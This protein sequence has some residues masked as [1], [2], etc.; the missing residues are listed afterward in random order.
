MKMNVKEEMCEADINAMEMMTVCFKEED[1][2]WKSAHPNQKSLCIKD[3]DY[4]LVT[5]DFKEEN[6]EMPVSDETHKH[7]IMEHV[8]HKVKSELLQSDTKMTEGISSVITPE[9]QL[10]PTNQSEENFPDSHSFHQSASPQIFLQC[11][12]QQAPHEDN[13]KKSTSGS[14]IFTPTSLQYKSS[15]AVQLTSNDT[16]NNL[17]GVHSTNKNLCQDMKTNFKHK[18]RYNNGQWSH[19]GQKLYSCPDCDKQFSKKSS[20]LVHT[21][22]HTGEK[23][24]CCSDC[25]KQYSSKR[26]LLV[27]TT[28]HTGEKPYCCSDCGTQFSSKRSLQTHIR[29]HTGEKP[30]CCSEC[31]KQISSKRSLLV[32][33]RTHTGEKPYC[34]SECGK[35]FSSKC[36]LQTHIRI[37]NGVKPYSCSEC[38][39]QFSRMSHLRRHI[40]IHTGEKPY[41]CSECGKQFADS[42]GILKHTRIHT[43]GKSVRTTYYN[44]GKLNRMKT[45]V[46]QECVVAK[47]GG[48]LL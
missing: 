7:K 22:T 19:T 11:R 26:S 30:Y 33:T 45:N 36:S 13:V 27:H 6:G 48:S 1:S 28:I 3:E 41:C 37:H 21:R 23:P 43:S 24:Y 40:R 20:L 16:I 15:T 2:D 17:Q 4:E 46:V 8:K 5:V 32:H 34:C 10:P 25:G 29:I 12:P 35:K 39:R 38:G 42:S 47:D 44:N 14:E 18:F 31:G 9:D